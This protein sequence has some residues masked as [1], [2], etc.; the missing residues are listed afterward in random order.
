MV[1]IL[2]AVTLSCGHCSVILRYRDHKV[3]LLIKLILHHI[4]GSQ[5]C[6]VTGAVNIEI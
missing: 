6:K 5:E 4:L 2:Q 1:V 3:G